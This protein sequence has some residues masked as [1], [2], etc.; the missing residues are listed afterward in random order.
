PTAP[1]LPSRFS[2]IT[3]TPAQQSK[4]NPA[5]IIEPPACYSQR[6][7]SLICLGRVRN[8]LPLPVSATELDVVLSG[9]DGE[10][11]ARAVIER[12]NIPP[13]AYAPYSVTFSADDLAGRDMVFARLNRFVREAVTG[14]LSLD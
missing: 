3:A 12:S 14:V 13:A 8:T 10:T 7:G 1:P 5:L 2:P 4:E 9:S 6:D 11:V